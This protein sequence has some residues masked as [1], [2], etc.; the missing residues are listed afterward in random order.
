MIICASYF[1][2]EGIIWLL[3]SIL[4]YKETNYYRNQSWNGLRFFWFT[5]GIY[6][7]VKTTIYIIY[8]QEN[9]ILLEK[10]LFII[11][12]FFSFLLFYYSI[13]RPYD[14][15]YSNIESIINDHLADVDNISELN[16][17]T[18]DDSLIDRNSSL[19][20]VDTFKDDLLYNII[21]EKNSTKINFYVKINTNDF[22][23]IY[24][25]YF[26]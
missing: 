18:N 13:F 16:S 12:F 2:F 9:K 11:Q 4:L 8:A 17:I 23:F 5:N 24:F 22:I 10:I 19:E 14:F 7:I 6:I 1:L 3:S 21:I 20:N 15:R 26:F 25:Y